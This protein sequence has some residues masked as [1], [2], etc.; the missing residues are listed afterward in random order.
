MRLS[1]KAVHTQDQNASATGRTA[2]FAAAQARAFNQTQFA[3]QLRAAQV[4]TVFVTLTGSDDQR[5]LAAR[6]AQRVAADD[7]AWCMTLVASDNLGA[8][9]NQ[10]VLAHG[11]ESTRIRLGNS[12]N[13]VEQFFSRACPLQQAL[14]Q[15]VTDKAVDAQDQDA[16]AASG[17]LPER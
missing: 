14:G 9:D 1:D 3:G 10:F 11:A 5:V 16:G 8:P 6:D 17:H 12:A 2:G 7:L 15:V 13:Q 4:Q